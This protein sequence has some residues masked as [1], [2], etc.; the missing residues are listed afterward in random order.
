MEPTDE[1]SILEVGAKFVQSG[2]VWWA[3]KPVYPPILCKKMIAEAEIEDKK[4]TNQSIYV[5]FPVGN[6]NLDFFRM[7][8]N[9]FPGPD[10][11]AQ[12]SAM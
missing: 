11:M 7:P 9:S 10:D 8:G 1:A 6:K 12:D 3:K 2:H 5:I 4:H